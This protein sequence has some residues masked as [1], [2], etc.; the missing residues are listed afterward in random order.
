MLLCDTAIFNHISQI[1]LDRR[2]TKVARSAVTTVL[3]ISTQTEYLNDVMLDVIATARL[4]SRYSHSRLGRYTEDLIALAFRSRLTPYEL[5]DH[6]IQIKESDALGSR[7]LGELDYI[8][9]RSKSSGDTLQHVEVA[10]KF[11]LLTDVQQWLCP[12]KW[13]GAKTIDTLDRKLQHT[14]N[15][16]LPLSERQTIYPI[17]DRHPWFLGWGFYPFHSLSS[18]QD[19]AAPL[20]CKFL[21]FYAS[22]FIQFLA[23]GDGA[24]MR[25]YALQRMAWIGGYLTD[26]SISAS[27]LLDYM[28]TRFIPRCKHV[29][30]TRDPSKRYFQE[31]PNLMLQATLS[32]TLPSY[33]MVVV[34]DGWPDID[35]DYTREFEGA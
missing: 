7:T 30:Q 1:T 9:R 15:H 24:S 14:L 18:Q 11:F 27:T 19:F 22:D 35:A 20:D 31:M 28:R 33:R 23:N 2:S 17:D 12:K 10:V 4:P 16:Q 13:I 25:F 26:M 6:H 34:A 29:N 8:V 3:D 32:E 21:W 5:V